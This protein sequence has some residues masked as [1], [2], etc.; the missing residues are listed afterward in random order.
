MAL[1]S[2]WRVGGGWVVLS[3][4]GLS[5]AACPCPQNWDGTGGNGAALRHYEATGQRY[6]LVVKLGTITPHGADVYSYSSDE[7][8]MVLDPHLPE[9]LAH[10]GIN[11]LV[12]QKTE[13]S[14]TELEI[15]RN[16][17]FEFDRITE[18]GATLA[19]LAGPGCDRP[20]PGWLAGLA[21][22]AGWLTVESLRSGCTRIVSTGSFSPACK[23]HLVCGPQTLV[24]VHRPEEP[25][26]QLLHEQRAA[27]ALDPARG[28]AALRAGG[29]AHLPNGAS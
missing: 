24:Q 4:A 12:M 2:E 20:R 21:G 6:P 22:W 23:C 7:S 13:K 8:D 16:L 25:G 18:A 10:W 27:A 15:E 19:P 17:A 5:A 26:Q 14:M 3:A 9:H 29:R 28:A 11:M 1:P